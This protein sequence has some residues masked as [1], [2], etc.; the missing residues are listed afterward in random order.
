MDVGNKYYQPTENWI[1]DFKDNQLLMI[2]IHTVIDIMGTRKS[3]P[4]EF[5]IGP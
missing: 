2:L 1:A 3:G 4:R 5:S